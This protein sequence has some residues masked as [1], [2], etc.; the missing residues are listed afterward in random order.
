M[1]GTHQADGNEFRIVQG[2]EAVNSPNQWLYIPADS[3]EPDITAQGVVLGAGV[4]PVTFD[5]Q[6]CLYFLLGR[7][8]YVPGWHGSE[9]WSAFEGGS[10]AVDASSV[11]HTAAREYIEESL[12]V[13]HPE[14]ECTRE[15]IDGVA[16]QLRAGDFTLRVTL[17]ILHKRSNRKPRFHVT[18]VRAFPWTDDLPRAFAEQRTALLDAKTRLQNGEP[19]PD[20]VAGHAA[21]VQGGDPPTSRVAEDFLEKSEVKLWSMADIRE[22]ERLQSEQKREIFRPCFLRTARIVIEEFMTRIS[23]PEDPAE[24]TPVCLPCTLP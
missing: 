17:K 12:G 15:L 21:V 4:L 18:F 5:P 6:G 22:A 1:Q 24:P 13:L 7:E 9:S 19:L 11:F 23:M 10:K 14:R 2:G 20:A 3:H 16:D 8:H